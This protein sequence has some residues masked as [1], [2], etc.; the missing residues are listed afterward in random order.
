MDYESQVAEQ[1]GIV[2]QLKTSI[3]QTRLPQRT[4]NWQHNNVGANPGITQRILIVRK[5]RKKMNVGVSKAR[6]KIKSLRES[7]LGFA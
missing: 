3:K 5:Q 1:E 7:I 4:I 6:N 2:S